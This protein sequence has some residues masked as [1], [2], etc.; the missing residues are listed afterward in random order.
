MSFSHPK[1]PQE[2]SE[3]LAPPPLTSLLAAALAGDVDRISA[4]LDVDPAL[5]S[6][7]GLLRGHTGL[8]TALHHAVSGR[9]EAAVRLLLAR[10]ADPNVRDEGDDATPLHFAAEQNELGIISLL[11][12][13][14]AD[15][16]G[17]GTWHELDVLGW[18]TVFGPGRPDVVDYLLQ[19]GA[20]WTI[21]SAVAM[22]ADAEVRRLVSADPSLLAH[23]MDVTNL[24]R[25]PLHLAVV[26][27][28]P[29]TAAL[30]LDLGADPAALDA[31]GLAPL[32]L[33]AFLGQGQLAD[34][35]ITA[36]APVDLPAAIAL[37]RTDDLDRLMAAEPGALAPGG[38]WD[39]LIV[40]AAES[41]PGEIVR[42]LL[43]LGASVNVRD[44]ADAAVDQA[45]GYTPL[46]AAAFRGNVAGVEVLLEH[47]ADVAA[48]DRGA[49]TRTF[50]QVVGAEAGTS[51]WAGRAA[52]TPLDLA[53]SLHLEEMEAA[54]LAAG[55][56]PSARAPT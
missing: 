50:A 38:R 52:M 54:L 36:G 31:S 46:H 18:A 16:V 39:T 8:R 30:L 25:T 45:T 11:V 53:R 34:R 12:E 47:G 24:R 23:R 32:A 9:H 35:L 40:R 17:E 41:S 29:A 48:R 15:T 26:K 33:A 2:G 56:E 44:R 5:V 19:H 51:P 42:R 55:G 28:H 21:S 27:Q 4:I 13:H 14:G 10:G 49:L 20:R 7:R 43:Q 6:E 22:G 3:A 37:G 1:A